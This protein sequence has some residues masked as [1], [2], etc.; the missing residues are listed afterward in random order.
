MDA[1]T[2]LRQVGGESAQGEKRTQL[3]ELCSALAGLDS[4]DGLLFE[5]MEQVAAFFA[6]ERAAV[7][8]P[9]L[10]TPLRG[11]VWVADSFR[12]L[13]LPRDPGNLVGGAASARSPA[14]I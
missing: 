1:A 7:F 8:I 13:R 12:E 6:A 11:V 2:W 3:S 5:G 4:L 14:S 10:D 9:D